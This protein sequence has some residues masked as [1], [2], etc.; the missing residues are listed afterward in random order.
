MEND[1]RW[2]WSPSGSDLV[3]AKH[4]QDDYISNPRLLLHGIVPGF[5]ASF[6]MM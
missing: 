6:L 2:W 4:I 3:A 1:L 5:D